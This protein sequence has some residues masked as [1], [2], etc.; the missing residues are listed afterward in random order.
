MSEKITIRVTFGQSAVSMGSIG[1]VGE[2]IS[3]QILFDC[4]SALAGRTSTANIVC[5]IKRPGDTNPY[6][7]TLVRMDNTS[8]YKLVLTS[9]EVAVAGT[10][11]FELRMVDG[12][13]VLKS[14]ICTGSVSSSMTGIADTP[15]MPLPDVLN[16]LEAALKNAE[17]PSTQPTTVVASTPMV[18][19][20]GDS[21][22]QGIGGNV[23]GWHMISYPQILSERCNAVN[24][25]ILSD[26]VPT[27]QARQ[28]SLKILLPACT[29][30]ASCAEYVELGSVDDGLKLDDGSVA[31]LLK[32]GDA[33]INPCYVNDVPCILFRDYKADTTKGTT[34]RLRRL[35]DGEA[36]T[37]AENTPLV[38]YAAKHYKGN[39]HI[40]WMGA[41]GGYGN[42]TDSGTD[43]AF[44]DYVARL[45]ACVE[46]SE[47]DDYLI[48]YSRERVGYTS[49]EA[50]EKAILAE[51]FSGH[52]VDLVPQLCDRGLLYGETS[53]WDGT[54]KNG[55]PSTL[56]SG[57]GCHFS[58][59]G[60]RAIANI[61]WE[62]LYPKIAKGSFSSGSGSGTPVTPTPEV[63]GD[64]FGEWAYKLKKAKTFTASTT[65][66]STD[67]KPFAEDTGDFTFA[68]RFSRDA[69]PNNN[70]IRVFWM[71]EWFV[72]SG[73]NKALAFCLYDNASGFEMPKM[74]F[75]LAGGAFKL[76][77]DSM[78]I[79]LPESDYHTVIISRSGTKYYNYIDGKLIYGAALD[80]TDMGLT[81]TK[82]ITIGGVS[83]E[84]NFIGTVA[85]VRIY[86]DFFDS[87]KCA[88][89]YQ[90][91]NE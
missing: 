74:S 67:F 69:Q 54:K 65:P 28:G 23:N 86:N 59:Y 66:I 4:S 79:T 19:C 72:V 40:F 11:Q 26:N 7:G 34:F 49:D 2:N 91:M 38:T 81:S 75:L 90:A 58:F 61:I 10:V 27:I 63:T 43:L 45:K 52:F 39:I 36:V 64:E 77:P 57:D 78:S 80:Y 1:R 6:P 87:D 18:Y 76:D 8:T 48:I 44:D 60:Y 35:E 16:R 82:A 14:A 50:G 24:L 68:I 71:Q 25:G 84:N 20:W 22:T 15:E 13:E 42:K 55:V 30:P 51:T 56:D 37:V 5:A 12:A 85:D 46:F 29:I 53:L 3:R 9:A 88:E 31:H 33:G 21:L 32:Y 73:A 17:Q 83:G 70:L 89:L 47:A 41:N 62:Y